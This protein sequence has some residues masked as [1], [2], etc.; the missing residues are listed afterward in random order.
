M[1]AEFIFAALRYPES[2]EH[3]L[4][5]PCQE[6]LDEINLRITSALATIEDPAS[7]EG[8][9][10][11]F[12][13][14]DVLTWKTQVLE[15]TTKFASRLF[16]SRELWPHD[17]DLFSP[18]NV[19]GASWLLTG[20]ETWGDAPT[21]SYDDLALLDAL[22]ITTEPFAVVVPSGTPPLN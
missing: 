19:G 20:A 14:D 11:F 7:L 18:H 2:K 6:L 3:T 12:F 16:L 10:W 22:G 21:N 17:L 4:V 13:D 15:A 8:Y 5:P 9:G 1:G